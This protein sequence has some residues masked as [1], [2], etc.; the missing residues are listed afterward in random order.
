MKA[1]TLVQPYATLIID[2]RK[3]IETRSWPTR[4]HSEIAIH[5]GA[6]VNREACLRFGYDPDAIPRGAVLGIATLTECV[7][8]PHRKAPPD[9]YGDFTPGRYGF[10]LA[11][12]RAFSKPIPAKGKLSLWNWDHKP[13]ALVK[14]RH[15]AAVKAW[16]TRRT[17]ARRR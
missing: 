16:Q 11:D 15:N 8:F 14:T 12:V 2:K 10:L 17:K 4:H 5:A 3:R 1:I 9:Q 7:Q 13:S 6:K